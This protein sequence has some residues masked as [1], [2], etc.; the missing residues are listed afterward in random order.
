MKESIF[1]L[2]FRECRVKK[3]TTGNFITDAYKIGWSKNADGRK[4]ETEFLKLLNADINKDR[5]EADIE[6][7][8]KIE[9]PESFI[10]SLEKFIISEYFADEE[11]Y[12]GTAREYFRSYKESTKKFDHLVDTVKSKKSIIDSKNLAYLEIDDGKNNLLSNLEEQYDSIKEN[13]VTVV[14]KNILKNIA[15]SEKH[16][17]I[18]KDNK[19]P[20]ID[21]TID[22]R[23]ALTRDFILLKSEKN[24]KLMLMHKVYHAG[25]NPISIGGSFSAAIKAEKFQWAQSSFTSEFGY[26]Q[27][28]ISVKQATEKFGASIINY[29]DANFD[30]SV[31]P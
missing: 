6:E 25:K 4:T 5:Y 15:N 19:Q 28:Q 3:T 1:E 26:K 22:I 9:G 30:K 18:T 29:D 16:I 31:L 2:Y 8:L 7:I 20:I 21:S 11:K 23:D 17:N 27:K 13:I 12:F 10:K 14:S 24:N